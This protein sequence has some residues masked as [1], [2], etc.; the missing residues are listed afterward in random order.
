MPS[1][2]TIAHLPAVHVSTLFFICALMPALLFKGPQIEF[3][4]MTQ[5]VLMLWLGWVFLCSHDPGLR[6]SKTPL[7]ISLTLFWLWLALSLTGSLAPSISVVNFW[8]VGSLAL[9]FWL[10]TLTPDRDALWSHAAA[11]LLILGVVMGLMGIYQVLVLEQNAR[12]VFE[13]R[14]T[15]A[16]FLNL[17]AVPASAYLLMVMSGKGLSRQHVILLSVILYVLFFSIFMTASRGA[18]LSLGLSLGL[19][20]AFTFRHVPWR[21]NALLLA[22]T[23]IAFLSTKISLGGGELSQRLPQLMQDAPRMMIWES[24]WN[25]LQS[26]PWH[27]IGLGLFYLAYPAFRNPLDRSGGF[28]AH[29]DYLQIWIETGLPGLLLLIS[30]LG[31]CLWLMW[32]VLRKAD[33]NT[34]LEVSG[35]FCGLMAVASHSVVDFNLYILSIM[36]VSGLVLGRFHDLVARG[37]KLSSFHL[38][39]SRVVGKQA[40]ST[41]I[42]LL[43]LMPIFYFVALGMANSYYDKGLSQARVGKLQESDISLASAHRLTPSDDRSLIAHADLYRHAI[44]ILPDED[45]LGKKALYEQAL[46]FLDEAQSANSLR[47]LTFIIRGRLYQQ[48][49]DLVGDAGY[50]L[51]SESFRQALALNPLLFQG[52]MDYA[53]QLLQQGN[54][55]EALRIMDE[56]AEFYYHPIPELIPFY[57]LT[58]KLR[59]EA[60][61]VEEAMAVEKMALELETRTKSSYFLRGF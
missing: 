10:Y 17:V 59:R 26:A 23:L 30:V 3:F 54:K 1:R 53:G 9:V 31:S 19:L 13:T 57:S 61:R 58:G 42:I 2:R 25:L 51:A 32:R 6:I 11:I 43:M 4:A 21:A 41:V 46:Q 39:P 18:T 36:M 12:S 47:A 33:K 14:N 44:S 20:I 50:Q 48:N 37:L 24:S 16:A 34:R 5:V 55:E 38:R 28:F 35:L 45:R 49:S 15:L 22:L 40:Y 27:G 60:G 52:R 7:A 29:N 8:W 56:G